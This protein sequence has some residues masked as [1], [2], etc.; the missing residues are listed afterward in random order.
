[1]L[2]KDKIMYHYHKLDHHDSIWTPGSE[3]IVDQNFDSDLGKVLTDFNTSVRMS[4]GSLETF[5][6]VL[7]YYLKD[8]NI[9]EIDKD[10]L[11]QILI[12]SKRIIGAMNV[13]NREYVLEE[14]RKQYF[15]S[16][17][18]RLHSI[19]VCEKSQ[20]DFWKNSLKG[21]RILYKV[22][23]NGVLFHSS[24]DF[25]PNETLTISE[26]MEDAKRYWDPHF[27]TEEEKLNSEYLFQ[28]EVKVMKKIKEIR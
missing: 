14:V 12:E 2:V 27:Q 17:P 25:L 23:L 28:G 8:D 1:M 16:L 3:F 5:D 24:D 10:L 19:W 9:E 6:R 22:K 26:M 18:S 21:T 4:D 20:L 7:S 13:Y 11:K 15:N